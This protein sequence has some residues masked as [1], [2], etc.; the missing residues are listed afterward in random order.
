M[1]TRDADNANHVRTC[2]LDIGSHAVQEVRD[3]D[4]VRFLR[5]ILQYGSSLRER[6]RHHDIDGSADRHHIK[7][8]VLAAELL[9]LNA[10]SAVDNLDLGTER[11]KTL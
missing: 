7:K 8:D 2:A 11:A 4:D 5:R 1:K 6:R 10:Y 9:A 3:I